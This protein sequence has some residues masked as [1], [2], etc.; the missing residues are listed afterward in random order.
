MRIVVPDAE[1]IK[2]LTALAEAFRQ[3]VVAMGAWPTAIVTLGVVGLLVVVPGVREHFRNKR[4]DMVVEHKE[5]EIE[6]L[7]ED[8][9]LY[10]TAYLKQVGVPDRVLQLDERDSSAAAA[11]RGVD[12]S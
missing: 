11:E 4:A 2:A 12:R 5:R 9:R 3:L 7:A 8:N 1:T 6:R 10:R